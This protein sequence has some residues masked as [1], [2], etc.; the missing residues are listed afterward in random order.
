[1]LQ[2][3]S[4][5]DL[6]YH[7][8]ESEATR[9]HFQKCVIHQ[10]QECTQSYDYK[11]NTFGFEITRSQ[12]SSFVEERFHAFTNIHVEN[13]TLCYTF[14]TVEVITGYDRFRQHLLEILDKRILYKCISFAALSDIFT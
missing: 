7:S 1:M 13:S 5:K 14:L 3:T 11:K 4:R 10:H 8:T 2:I 6:G 9:I 12:L